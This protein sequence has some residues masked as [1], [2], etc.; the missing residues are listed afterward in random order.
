MTHP[1]GV[2]APGRSQLATWRR[3]HSAKAYF[4]G[5]HR[6]AAPAET[7]ERLRPLLPRMGITRVANVTGLDILGIPVVMVCRPNSRALAVSQGKGLTLDAAKVSGIME[8]AE[9]YHA[10]RLSGPL[11]LTTHE[12]MAGS[13]SLV[14]VERLPIA[15]GARFHRRLP[16]LWVEGF[17]LL[18][19]EW[20][21][22]PY[23]SV[24]TDF[25]LDRQ[26]DLSGFIPTSNGLA[27]GNTLLEALSHALLELVE[28][29]AWVV[30][31]MLPDARK[32][33]TRVD[34]A[35]V[36]GGEARALLDRL[37][38]SGVGVVLWETTGDIRLPSFRCLIADAAP[39]PFRPLY[40]TYGSGCHLS[41]EVALCRAIT[42]AVQSRL[43][44]VSGARDD[45]LAADY[46]RLLDPGIQQ[47]VAAV[48]AEQ[49]RRNFTEA[50]DLS[51]PSF[52]EDVAAELDALQQAGI[53]SAVVVDLTLAEI[54]IPVVK[55]VV[56][57]LEMPTKLGRPPGPRALASLRR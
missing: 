9:S 17:D 13:R 31:E 12:E 3:Q 40:V 41:R 34:L 38:R 53:K 37:E 11:L 43:T 7:L 19:E 15:R 30:W 54:A 16:I 42:E 49:G 55:C 23:D 4:A 5:T 20:A 45:I 21:W 35:S 24:H 33:S 25:T 32:R 36:R 18:C 14:D 27:S 47:H 10:E 48:L 22:L 28:R 44:L 51:T 26:K 2:S 1:K 50:P 56:P 46:E 29:D 8:S 39:D 52:D 57:G 6:A